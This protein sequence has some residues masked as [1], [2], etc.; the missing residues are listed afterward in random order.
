MPLHIEDYAL[1]GD[2]ETAA[3]VGRDSFI[4]G[5]NALVGDILSADARAGQ[6]AAGITLY[7]TQPLASYTYSSPLIQGSSTG[8]V[9]QPYIGDPIE[10]IAAD[11]HS[12][13]AADAAQNP[14]ITGVA[15]AGDAWINAIEDGV[16]QRNP[17][18]ANEPAGQV[19][20][21][22]GDVNAACCTTPIGYHPS[23]YGAYLNALVLFDQVTGLDASTFG[24]EETAAQ[25]L[26]I[27]PDQAVAL[28][29]VAAA[30]V[31]EP[32]SFA[33]LGLALAGLGGLLASR[34]A[35]GTGPA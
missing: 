2:C 28:E 23:T 27:T 5:T 22:D 31:P 34:R 18:L 14:A 4:S 21:W 8:G 19:D 7:E 30:T 10:A 35:S 24:A 13:Y 16:A 3:L 12:A 1:I 17:Y 29:Q 9:N 20:L 6:K 32:P 15:Y 25:A 11:L 26:G 33:L